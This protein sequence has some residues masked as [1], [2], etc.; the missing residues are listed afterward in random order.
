M[1]LTPLPRQPH[2]LSPGMNE[3]EAALV[4]G[5]SVHTLRS[6][7]RRGRGPAFE[8]HAGAKRRGRGQAGRVVY[9]A[10]AIQAYLLKITVET[11]EP[12]MPHCS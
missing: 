12:A 4:L 1:S 9:R 6:W 8:K 10:E 5:L 11:D 7:R 2:P 3:T